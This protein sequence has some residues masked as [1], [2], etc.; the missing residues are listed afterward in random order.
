MDTKR[1]NNRKLQNQNGSFILKFLANWCT[2][3]NPKLV[4][5]L[6]SFGMNMYYV[7]ILTDCPDFLFSVLSLE[8]NNIIFLKSWSVSNWSWFIAKIQKHLFSNFYRNLMIVKIFTNFNV[9]HLNEWNNCD[10]Y[11]YSLN[12]FT[13]LQKF[14]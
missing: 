5:V 9:N 7:Q 3:A 12:G 14:I 1:I 10:N 2:L 4:I 11:D 8:L 13:S 6:S